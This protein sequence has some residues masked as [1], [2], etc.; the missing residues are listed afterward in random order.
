MS[1]PVVIL[2]TGLSG[3]GAAREFRKLDKDTPLVV[4]SRDHAGFYSKPMLSNALAGNKTAALAALK[5]A[6]PMLARVAQKGVVHKRSASRK[7]SRSFITKR[8]RTNCS[9]R[10]WWQ[11]FTN[12]I[13]CTRLFR[14]RRG[15]VLFR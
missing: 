1:A 15:A 8:A 14:Q 4:V 13:L 3:Y 11:V 9:F 5:S 6:E 7:I 2:G 12:A 10:T